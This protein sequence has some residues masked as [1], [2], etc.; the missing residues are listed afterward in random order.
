M[1]KIIWVYILFFMFLILGFSSPG[2]SD[3]DNSDGNEIDDK[4]TIA[5]LPEDKTSPTGY[6]IPKDLEGT[7]LTLDKIL[8]PEFIDEIKNNYENKLIADYHFGLCL[9]IRNNWILPH[10]RKDSPESPL[11]EYFLSLDK[12]LY[13]DD[14]SGIIIYTY[15]R[16]LNGKPL[17]LNEELEKYDSYNKEMTKPVGLASPIDGAEI[18]FLITRSNPCEGEERQY[19][20]FEGVGKVPLVYEGEQQYAEIEGIGKVPLSCGPQVHLGRT[21]TDGTIWAYQYKKGLFEPGPK[22]IKMFEE[23]LSESPYMRLKKAP[24]SEN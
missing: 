11:T 22:L 18:E 6:Y 2:M 1:L 3:E 19:I 14:M 16:R 13:P 24:S 21:K 23:Y 5:Q 15:W 12:I 10:Y 4:Y 7:F 8:T 17:R 9:W 20:E